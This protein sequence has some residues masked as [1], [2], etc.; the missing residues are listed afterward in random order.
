VERILERLPGVAAATVYPVPD[1]RTGDQVM[2][3]L[4]LGPDAGDFDPQ[5]FAAA[6]AADPDL[7]TKWAPRFVRVAPD[8]PLTATSKVDRGRLR[9]ERWDCP[10]PVYWR[11]PGPLTAQ[12]YAPLTAEGRAALRQEFAAYGRLPVLDMV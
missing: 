10:D 4:V 12:G 9:R 3:T 2:A 11:P 8:L 6:L 5:A 7:G 1:P